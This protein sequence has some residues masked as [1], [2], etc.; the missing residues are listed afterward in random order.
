MDLINNA[1]FNCKNCFVG[2][3]LNDGHIYLLI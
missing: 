2:A 1:V 3:T